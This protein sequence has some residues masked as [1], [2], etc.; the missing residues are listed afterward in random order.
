MGTVSCEVQG[1]WE[2]LC[3]L[4]INGLLNVVILVYWWSQILKE[5]NPRDGICS[6]YNFFAEDVPWVLSNLCT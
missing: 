1:D 6:D 4:C 5:Q 2:N 3:A